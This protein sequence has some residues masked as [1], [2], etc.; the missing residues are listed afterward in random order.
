MYDCF[1]DDEVEEEDI[2]ALLI[3][4]NQFYKEIDETQINIKAIAVDGVK[5]KPSNKLQR[6]SVTLPEFWM[7]MIRLQFSWHFQGI[8]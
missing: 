2:N 6:Q 3:K 7:R 1:D 4:V 8:Q 5:K